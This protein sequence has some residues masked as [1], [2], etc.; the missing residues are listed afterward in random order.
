MKKFDLVTPRYSYVNRLRLPNQS[1]QVSKNHAEEEHGR[2]AGQLAISF[3]VND[4]K[5]KKKNQDDNLPEDRYEWK[6][7]ADTK[8]KRSHDNVTHSSDIHIPLHIK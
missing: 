6:N 7:S 3:D 5:N 2:D 8:R 1:E 4:S